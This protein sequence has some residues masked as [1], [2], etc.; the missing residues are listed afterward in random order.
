MNLS[1]KVALVTGST[2]DVGPGIARDVVGFTFLQLLL[3]LPFVLYLLL[4]LA[5]TLQY[6]PPVA[7]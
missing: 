5:F 1:N 3:H 7:P 2:S 6:H 4:A